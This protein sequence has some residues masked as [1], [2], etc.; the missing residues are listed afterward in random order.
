MNRWLRSLYGNLRY[1]VTHTSKFPKGDLIA[2][3]LALAKRGFEP[4]HILDV[5]AN[6]GKWSRKASRVFPR[7]QFTLIEPQVEM[8]CHL[9]AF[10]RRHPGAQWINAGAGASM[11]RKTF[12]VCPDTVSSSF[13]ISAE[14]AGRRGYQRREVDIVTLDHIVADHIGKVPELVK[15]DAEG[16][17]V[18]ILRGAGSL[19]GKSELFLLEAHFFGPKSHPCRLQNLIPLMA[20][21][22]YAPYDFTTFQF[23][24]YDH[25]IGLC[26]IAFARE[27]G[28]LRA[29]ADWGWPVGEA[30]GRR[31][32]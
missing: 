16:F 30:T 9:D 6:R 32:A 31:A 17:E 15:I 3:F 4:T 23:R 27:Q 2:F 28:I 12:T 19:L 26:E 7:C 29:H 1:R 22:G 13:A 14:E 10:C 21:Y 8:A 20:E 11:D 25:A 18:E 24:P 5:G